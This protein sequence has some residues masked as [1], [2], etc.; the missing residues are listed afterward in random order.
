MKKHVTIS[1]DLDIM[2]WDATLR[3]LYAPVNKYFETGSMLPDSITITGK[4]KNVVFNFAYTRLGDHPS[5]KI[6]IRQNAHIFISEW[7]DD[8]IEL[9]LT[10]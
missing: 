3:R 10:F 5:N 8:N 2:T 7:L 9:W 6:E 4:T 1:L